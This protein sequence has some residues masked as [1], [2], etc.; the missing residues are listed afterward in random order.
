[1]VEL[2]EFG[3]TRC[4]VVLVEG[5]EHWIAGS[6]ETGQTSVLG[7]LDL[8]W[9][10]RLG[11]RYVKRSSSPLRK[12]RNPSRGVRGPRPMTGSQIPLPMPGML[13]IGVRGFLIRSAWV[14]GLGA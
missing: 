1:M 6:P 2:E 4:R 5:R 12:S 7:I 8:L 10:F 11:C 3:E 9:Q 13:L 14:E